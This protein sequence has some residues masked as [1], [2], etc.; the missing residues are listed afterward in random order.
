MAGLNSGDTIEVAIEGVCAGQKTLNVLH[1][2]VATPSVS[3]TYVTAM[4]AF[5]SAWENSATGPQ[6]AILAACAQNWTCVRIR[7]QRIWPTRDIALYR[8]DGRPGQVGG[9]AEACNL[10]QVITKHGPLGTRRDVGSIHLPGLATGRF[11]D[12]TLTNQQLTALNAVAL[13]LKSEVIVPGDQTSALPVLV[14]KATPGAVRPVV[15]TTPQKTVRVL[16]RRT[17]GRGE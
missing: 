16:R 12:S 4:E 9:N 10:A 3:G 6:L 5:L 17:V 15:A 14:G 7:G 13:K 11:T 1:Y 8:A 2:T